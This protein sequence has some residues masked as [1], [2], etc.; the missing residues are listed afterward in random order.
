MDN[1]IYM[2]PTTWNYIMENVDHTE[3]P[4]KSSYLSFNYSFFGYRVVLTNYMKPT[5]YEHWVYP[6][7]FFS[8][9][10]RKLF[11]LLSK[12]TKKT[13]RYYCEKWGIGYKQDFVLG[14]IWGPPPILEIIRKK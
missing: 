14:E 13:E 5:V 4:V 8:K 6:N 11:R 3:S 1:N 10:I 9:K 12:I 2:H 7:T